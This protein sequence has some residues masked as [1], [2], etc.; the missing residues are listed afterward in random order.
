MTADHIV[1]LVESLAWP[2]TLGLLLVFFRKDLRALGD[3]VSRLRYREAEIELSQLRD[4]IDEDRARFIEPSEVS[5]STGGYYDRR[6][7][8]L[9]RLSETEPRAAVLA[10]YIE[11]ERAVALAARRNGIDSE[12]HLSRI[13]QELSSRRLIPASYLDFVD[14]LR[15]LRNQAAHGHSFDLGGR[16]AREFVDLAINLAVLITSLS[17]GKV[18]AGKP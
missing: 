1:Q 2:V 3:R 12:T 9:L 4:Q 11:L 8:E 17:G 10:S 18:P 15:R 13:L 14:E 16:I 6:L 5:A 7:E